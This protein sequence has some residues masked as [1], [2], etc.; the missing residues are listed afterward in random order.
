MDATPATRRD[1]SDGPMK[2]EHCIRFCCAWASAHTINSAAPFGFTHI[3]FHLTRLPSAYLCTIQV[4]QQ[5]S[6]HPTT[7]TTTST[8]PRSMDPNAPKTISADKAR[9]GKA[10]AYALRELNKRLREFEKEFKNMS[11]DDALSLDI[12]FLMTVRDDKGSAC[13]RIAA[14]GPSAKVAKG[15]KG[16]EQRIAQRI[17]QRQGPCSRKSGSNA[18]VTRL[19]EKMRGVE[20]HDQSGS[21]AE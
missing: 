6:H 11:G 4:S 7:T 12:K 2:N 15:Q 1:S 16:L 13:R 9:V 10:G 20:L 14:V 21:A 3:C 5:L 17:A 8:S 18:T 19:E